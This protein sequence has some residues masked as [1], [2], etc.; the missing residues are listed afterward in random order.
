M[1][2]SYNENSELSIVEEPQILIDFKTTKSKAT[3]SAKKIY[4]VVS[5][6]SGCGGLDLGFT[7]GFNF[8]DRHFEKNKFKILIIYKLYSVQS[9]SIVYIYTFH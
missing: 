8:R 6:F 2:K 5:L 4:K 7:G 3:K 1:Y 9:T